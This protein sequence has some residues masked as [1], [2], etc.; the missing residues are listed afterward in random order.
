M[1]RLGFQKFVR[2][3]QGR[4][5]SKIGGPL[6]AL[7]GCGFRERTEGAS[8]GSEAISVIWWRNR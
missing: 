8:G 7:H 4:L 3:Q 2:G 5:P 1:Q 6:V